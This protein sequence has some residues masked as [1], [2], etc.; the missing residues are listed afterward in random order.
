MPSDTDATGFPPVIPE[1]G[2]NS[3]CYGTASGPADGRAD[4]LSGDYYAPVGGQFQTESHDR[5]R[6]GIAAAAQWQSLDRRALLTAQ[7]LNSRAT[8]SWGE[9]EFGVGSD[10]SEYNTFPV[11]CLQ[12]G[13]GIGGR[14]R[15]EC[16][17]GGFTNY[18]YDSNNVFTNGYITLPGSGWRTS[19][20]GSSTT[21]VPTGG[22]QQ[23]LDDRQVKEKNVVQDPAVNFTFKPTPHWD[24]NLDAQYVKSEHDDLDMELSGSNFADYQMDL[25]G[26]FRSSPKS[27]GHN[28]SDLGRAVS[29]G[30]RVERSVFQ[31]SAVHLLAQRDGSHRAKQGP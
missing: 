29:A 28:E 7:F 3:P 16:P 17:V 5:K 24:I 4:F 15:A 14:T 11:G 30:Y 31:R 27:A 1:A 26:Q 22:S 18:Q 20:S 25:T 13:N 12:N 2:N 10:L 9:H 8:D 21:T 23:S 6:R 19:S